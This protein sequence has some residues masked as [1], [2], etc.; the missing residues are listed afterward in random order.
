MKNVSRVKYNHEKGDFRKKCN[1]EKNVISRVYCNIL[2][3][4]V[5][6]IIILLFDDN[7]FN[8]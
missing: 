8:F 2:T 3:T 4:N 5:N 1:N 7:C 6:L